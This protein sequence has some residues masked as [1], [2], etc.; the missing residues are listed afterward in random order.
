M[1]TAF[2][3]LLCVTAL[4]AYLNE[5]FIHFPTTVGVTL[6]GALASIVL[7]A[8]DALGLVPGVRG[9]AADLLK[10]LNFTNFVLNGILAVL[11]FAGALGLDARQL[12][13]Q[14]GSILTLAFL[15]TL[16]S[17]FLIGFA[18]YFV[19]GL[20]GLDVP[21]IWALLFGA[22]ISPT[23]PVAVLDLLKRARVPARIETLIAGESL[24]N[25]GVGV[26]IFLALAGVA[27]IGGRHD[28]GVSALEVL[29]LFVREAGGGLLFGG[30]L[31]VWGYLLLRSINQHAV[32]VLVTLA[33][34]VG[35]YV[36][37]AAM[38]I[39]GPLA[40]VVAGLVISANRHAVFSE[41][42]G[43]LVESFWET[44][45]QVLNILLFAF[46]GLDVLLT[47]TTGAQLIASAVLIVVALA[48]RWIS[49]ALPF[50]LV[51]AREGYGAYTVRLLTWGGL[52]GGIAISLALSLPASPH[53]THIVTVTYAI[54]LFTI[55]VQ[56]LT[57]LPLVRRA[58]AASPDG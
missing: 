37:A 7:I 43:E 54:V 48:A 13:R 53:R 32:E 26:V 25:D 50:A 19:F 28:G 17:T 55:A 57:I 56:G 4:L 9:W 11:L 30:I 3:T 10:T 27:G 42:T 16:I 29:T 20:L 31:G 51:R 24:F 23:D 58:A 46:I 12:L 45:D 35:G 8:L 52:R 14:R 39:S 2:A 33:L 47:R 34:V 6:S 18:A 40:M 36:A 49:V 41:E 5:R 38:G 44:I 22:L 15:S 21:L 1:L